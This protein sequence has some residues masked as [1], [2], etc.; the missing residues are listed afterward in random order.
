M[1]SE[2]SRVEYSFKKGSR[3]RQ[4]VGGMLTEAGGWRLRRISAL[5]GL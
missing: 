5:R 1:V 2:L 4:L 3:Q